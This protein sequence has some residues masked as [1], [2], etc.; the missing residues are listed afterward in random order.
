MV[1]IISPNKQKMN[2]KKTVII[3]SDH[4]GYQLKELF[5]STLPLEFIDMGPCDDR[6]VDYPEYA[7]AV[8]KVVDVEG[9]MGIL[10]CGSGEGMCMT[11]NKH[12]GIRAALCWNKEIAAATRQ[13]NDA[14]IL[15][16][17]ARFIDEVTAADI[18]ETFL[19]TEFEGG[20]HLRR[21][22]KIDI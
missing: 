12:P 11:A 20:R 7:H 5:K 15:C 14:N 18:L 2:D 3:G 10:I 17:P 21:I 16:L 6:S 13:H 22:R 1:F 8:A 19:S 4:A 9:H